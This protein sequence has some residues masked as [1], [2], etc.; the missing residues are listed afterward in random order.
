MPLHLDYNL[1]A[2]RETSAFLETIWLDCI[3]DFASGFT[4]GPFEIIA[5]K[6]DLMHIYFNNF[7]Y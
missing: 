1:E 7:Q 2:S 3:I 6:R 5:M 4:T